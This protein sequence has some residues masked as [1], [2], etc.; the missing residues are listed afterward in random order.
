[1]AGPALKAVWEEPQFD[2]PPVKDPIWYC[3]GSSSVESYP[4]GRILSKHSEPG[5]WEPSA[6]HNRVADRPMSVLRISHGTGSD[7]NAG[8]AR[9]AAHRRRLVHVAGMANLACNLRPSVRQSRDGTG[10]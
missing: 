7:T 8:S 6:F 1:M 5:F 10:R 9:I 4:G 2:K 3:S